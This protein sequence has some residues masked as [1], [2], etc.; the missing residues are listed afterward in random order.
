MAKRKKCVPGNCNISILAV[1]VP[2]IKNVLHFGRH[3]T[4]SGIDRRNSRVRSS[5][6]ELAVIENRRFA[7]EIMILFPATYI[8]YL[9]QVL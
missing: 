5:F 8:G 9:F 2:E 1:I 7:V 6:A 3:I 4:I